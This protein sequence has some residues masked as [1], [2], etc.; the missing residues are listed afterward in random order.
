MDAALR[1][2]WIEIANALT[3]NLDA[4]L[5]C[6]S[7]QRAN[8]EVLDTTVPGYDGVY[9]CHIWC[10]G[11]GARM[12]LLKPQ[13]RPRSRS[14][15]ALDKRF[16]KAAFTGAPLSVSYKVAST[17]ASTA[18]ARLPRT[19]SIA[20][21]ADPAGRSALCAELAD[22]LHRRL[23]DEPEFHAGVAKLIGEL[24][25]AGHD[26]W[27]FDADDDMEAWCPNYR[28]PT[29]P[30]IVITFRTD[31]VEIGY[32]GDKPAP[33][34]I[35]PY[36]SDGHVRWEIDIASMKATLLLESFDDVWNGT[37]FDL[38][39]S[40]G[41]W[42]YYEDEDT[43]KARVDALADQLVRTHTNFT[44][45]SLVGEV[46]DLV[47]TTRAEVAAQLAEARARGPSWIDLPKDVS[48]AI[49]ARWREES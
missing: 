11:C 45:L 28:T 3:A 27:S 47:E 39:R 1:Q 44:G 30:G 26:L 6:P 33:F 7:C 31:G 25:A 23:R 43:W 41:T 4:D 34:Q 17:G 14:S 13:G 46:K 40:E 18:C 8:I 38:R 29:G 16:A 2:K 5:E 19:M 35:E 37:T 22:V 21:E 36:E 48:K 32:S 20:A 12:S 15:S 9:E 42:Q 24:R 49:E 10:E